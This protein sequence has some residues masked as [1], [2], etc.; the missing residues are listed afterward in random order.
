[1]KNLYR[2]FSIGLLGTLLP[3]SMLAGDNEQK[4]EAPISAVTV[5]L[6]GAEVSHTKNITLVPGRNEL[7]F[8][9][10]QLEADSQKH[11]VHRNR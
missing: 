11:P 8:I 2:T 3:L 4:I 10:H 6:T 5:Y 9:A 7:L 1:M